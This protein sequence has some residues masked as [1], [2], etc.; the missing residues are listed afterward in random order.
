[1]VKAI[2]YVL[3]FVGLLL[4]AMCLFIGL[5]MG[6]RAEHDESI[7]NTNSEVIGAKEDK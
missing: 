4:I 2:K 7:E 3:G 6:D 1:M 5:V